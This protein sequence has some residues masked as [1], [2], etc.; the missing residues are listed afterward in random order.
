[1]RRFFVDEALPRNI[2]DEFKITGGDARH[3]TLVLRLTAG[4]EIAV[5]GAEPGGN[6]KTV[7]A[8]ITKATAASVT[9]QLKETLNTNTEPPL[10]IWLAQAL[11]KSDKMDFIV[12]K[13][14]EL[15]I[16]G[17]IPL[18]CEHCVVKYD[19]VKE[20]GRRERWQ[21]IAAEAAKQCGRLHVPAVLP[22]TPLA[23][24]FDNNLLSGETRENMAIIMLYE[25]A[26]G[27]GLKKTIAQHSPAASSWLLIVGPEG[28]FSAAEVA[29]CQNNGAAV[30][31]MGPRILRTETASLAAV[32]ALMYEFGDIG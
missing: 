8:V 25:G 29:F 20:T 5:A 23:Q 9:L 31:S 14:V 1:M 10:K 3:I 12:Q 7:R 19:H 2:G 26:G 13:A 22:V 11:P 16:S 21:K 24:L 4:D 15:G 17:I 27:Q 6:K 28:G 30:V 32:S 18:I